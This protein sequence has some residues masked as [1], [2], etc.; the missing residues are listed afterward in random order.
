[1]EMKQDLIQQSVVDIFPPLLFW[2]F[3]HHRPSCQ[4]PLQS[5]TNEEHRFALDVLMYGASP[6]TLVSLA[7]WWMD[8]GLDRKRQRRSLTRRLKWLLSLTARLF[9]FAHHQ[10]AAIDPPRGHLQWGACDIITRRPRSGLIV[11]T[12]S[13]PPSYCFMIWKVN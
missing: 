2:K 3:E 1:M 5:C 12:P 13:S 9:M 6:S 7:R 8:A 10:Q 11:W 4:Q